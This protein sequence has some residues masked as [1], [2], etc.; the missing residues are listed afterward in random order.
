MNRERL[1]DLAEAWSESRLTL[2]EA[3]ELS[4]MLRTSPEARARFL[5]SARLVGELH[6]ALDEI[7]M[8][9]AA[10]KAVAPRVHSERFSHVTM[11]LAFGLLFVS[12]G[13]LLSARADYPEIRPLGINDGGFDMIRGHLPEGFPTE[14]FT[15]G[16]DPSEIITTTDH[17]HVL[18][19]LEAAGEPN[20]PNSPSQ[21]CD[22]F[23]IIDLKSVKKSL[24]TSS[25]AY[26]EL[27]ANVLDGRIKRGKAVRF[28]AKVY[29][30]EGS[31]HEI[32]K[33]WPPQPDQVLASGA[34]FYVS[35]GL[36]P[37]EWK[38]IST[39]CVLPPTAGYMVIQIGA[40]SAGKPGEP[41][42][43]LGEQFADDIR[44]TMHTRQSK[45]E[46]A[47]R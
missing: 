46:V 45:T 33:N 7:N 8:D 34:Q 44:L 40:G 35:S 38:T 10:N 1:D 5:D 29:V 23:Q 13:W 11:L 2:S 28:I 26:V 24:A 31:P 27:Q 4:S 15:W 20:I 9:K 6:I 16:G 32:I 14:T 3:A 19:F 12:L 47:V 25:E 30:F 21:S 22:V 41:S 36:K 18:R 17:N 42:P 43:T 37:R 39:R